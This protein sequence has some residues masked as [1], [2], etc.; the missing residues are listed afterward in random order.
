MKVTNVAFQPFG[1]INR[2]HPEDRDF[3]SN[4]NVAEER[5]VFKSSLRLSPSERRMIH[6]EVARLKNGVR[7]SVVGGQKNVCGIS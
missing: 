4:R 2:R 5:R 1:K 7:A 3:A 6:D